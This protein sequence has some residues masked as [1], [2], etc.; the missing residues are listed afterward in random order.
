[1]FDKNGDL[2]PMYK[3]IKSLVDEMIKSEDNDE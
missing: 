3:F 2:E 1:M